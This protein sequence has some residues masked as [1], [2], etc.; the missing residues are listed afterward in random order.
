MFQQSSHSRDHAVQSAEVIDASRHIVEL[1]LGKR[2]Y[3]VPPQE[4]VALSNPRIPDNS[5]S[6]RVLSFRSYVN[7]RKRV[8]TND[9]F[10]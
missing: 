7:V 10:S 9:S 8:A 5:G 6:T 2:D 4:C 3:I 1:E